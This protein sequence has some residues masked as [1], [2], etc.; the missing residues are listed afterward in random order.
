MAKAADLQTNAYRRLDFFS[1]FKL[2]QL[3][4]ALDLRGGWSID[5]TAEVL[6]SK[7]F[8]FIRARSVIGH[9][10][11]AL[12]IFKRV[13]KLA[14]G[15]KMR[16]SV[17]ESGDYRRADN[18]WDSEAVKC[19]QILKYRLKGR[20]RVFLVPFFVGLLDVE[21]DEVAKSCHGNKILLGSKSAGLY[22]G[23]YSVFTAE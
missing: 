9:D 13:A 5:M 1:H 8:V 23:V 22:G 12:T 15:G 4:P 14:K 18:G 11:D 17:V 21:E 7:R 10:L 6:Y 16:R 2:Y 20:T 19:L 3:A